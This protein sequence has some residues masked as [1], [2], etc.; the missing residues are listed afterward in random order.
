M[1][2]KSHKAEQRYNFQ[3]CTVLPGPSGGGVDDEKEVTN[4]SATEAALLLLY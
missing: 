3:S 1:N 2:R 4:P